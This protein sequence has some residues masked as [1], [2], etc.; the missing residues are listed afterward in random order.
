M[1]IRKKE[2]RAEQEIGW[3]IISSIQVTEV[4]CLDLGGDVCLELRDIQCMTFQN[5]LIC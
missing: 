5:V 2:V 1:S 3:K 4:A